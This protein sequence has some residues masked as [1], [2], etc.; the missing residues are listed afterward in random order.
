MKIDQDDVLD[1]SENESNLKNATASKLENGEDLFDGT[2]NAF[3]IPNPGKTICVNGK[4]YTYED[5][6]NISNF[7]GCWYDIVDVKNGKSYLRHKTGGKSY[8]I[9]FDCDRITAFNFFRMAKN[10]ILSMYLNYP[11]EK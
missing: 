5:I 9:K 4:E 11:E 1:T 8:T 7:F 10:Y 2:F 6:L 3:N